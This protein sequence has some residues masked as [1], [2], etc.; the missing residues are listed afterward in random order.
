MLAPVAFDYALVRVVPSV[1]LGECVNVGVILF[2]RERR[3]LDARIELVPARV[4]ALWPTADL[5]EKRGT[6]GRKW[7]DQVSPIGMEE[8]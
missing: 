3:F 2:C 5:D 1:E 8:I 7:S 6:A 4:L